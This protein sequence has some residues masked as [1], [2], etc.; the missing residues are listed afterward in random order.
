MYIAQSLKCRSY[1]FPQY[2]AQIW[3]WSGSSEGHLSSRRSLLSKTLLRSLTNSENQSSKIGNAKYALKREVILTWALQLISSNTRW[4]S[5][6]MNL[7]F[8]CPLTQTGFCFKMESENILLKKKISFLNF[9]RPIQICI[10]NFP[11]KRT[12]FKYSLA[13]LNF[14]EA[15]LEITLFSCTVSVVRQYH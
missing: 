14:K 5:P 7:S 9:F 3:L 15:C 13:L 8:T 10:F 1:G 12:H 2:T 6:S 4:E 11:F